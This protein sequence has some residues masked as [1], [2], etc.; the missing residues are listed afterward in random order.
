[1]AAPKM[2]DVAD[3]SARRG[4]IRGLFHCGMVVTN[5]EE[6]LSFYRDLLGL[7]VRIFASTRSRISLNSLRA[8]GTQCASPSWKF[9]ARL[10]GSSL[11]NS[12]RRTRNA[13]SGEPQPRVPVL[14]DLEALYRRLKEAGVTFVGSRPVTITAG[15][16]GGQR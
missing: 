15:P 11:S 1:M 5:M 8:P 7:R 10:R 6:L 16:T 3:T 14:S 13:A 2:T 4:E 12:G 9:P